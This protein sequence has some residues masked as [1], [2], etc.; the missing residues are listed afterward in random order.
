MRTIIFLLLFVPILLV[1]VP[2]WLLF[3]LFRLITPLYIMGKVL[4]GLAFFMLGVKIQIRGRENIEKNKNYIID[5][6][7]AG[8]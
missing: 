4:A 7:K 6:T 5:I 8:S 2:F 1:T 3:S